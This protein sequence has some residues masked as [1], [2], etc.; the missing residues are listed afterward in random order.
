MPEYSM[1]V[2]VTQTGADQVTGKI[3]ALEKAMNAAKEKAEK[4]KDFLNRILFLQ[5]FINMV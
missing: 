1:V 3:N 5:Y 2:K 4:P